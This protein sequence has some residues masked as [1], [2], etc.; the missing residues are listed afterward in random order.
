MPN[1]EPPASGEIEPAK[2]VTLSERDI[3]DAARL[4]R[5]IS[6]GTPW[7]SLLPAH[8]WPRDSS[9]EPSAHADLLSRAR[10]LLHMRR[11]RTRH[12]T[13]VM[14]AEPAWD[15]LLL[16]YV[17]DASE[18]RQTIGHVAELVEA[19]LTTVLRWVG[20]LEK[21]Q[22]VTRQ[23]HATDRR[24]V[25]IRLTDKGRECLDAFLDELPA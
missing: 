20:Y 24:I 1:P 4:F 23:D 16:L 7:A 21:E 18:G 8:E 5:L 12:F 10:G 14:F 9:V 25:F 22:L 11:L 6:D 19:P 2:T 13:R 15:I 3:R 17:T